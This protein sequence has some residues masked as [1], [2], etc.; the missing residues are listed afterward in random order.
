VTSTIFLGI[1]SIAL[2]LIFRGQTAGFPPEALRLPGLLIWLVIG[3]AVL[4]I[5]E[6]IY[7]RRVARRT[8]A[9]PLADAPTPVNWPVMLSFSAAIVV[10][11]VLI[12]IIGYLVATPLF[13]AG[14]LLAGR[15][16]R[17]S[18]AILVAVGTSAFM[19]AVFVWA[20]S[21]PVKLLPFVN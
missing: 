18:T 14:T 2:A 1:A 21:L 16:I 10:Y 9:D 8:S 20:L 17:T 3:L 7:K 19:W 12:P 11:A 4:M 13:V 15:N 6:E 5:A